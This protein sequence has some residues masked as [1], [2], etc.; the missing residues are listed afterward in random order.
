MLSKYLKA[1]MLKIGIG[2]LVV[3]ESLT[4]RLEAVVSE[5]A[6]LEG[7]ASAPG[8]RVHHVPDYS[9]DE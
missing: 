8:Y 4:C 7:D 9:D 3:P 1:E 2:M 6:D 5:I